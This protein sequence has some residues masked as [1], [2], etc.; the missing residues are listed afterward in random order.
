[1]HRGTLGQNPCAVHLGDS[2]PWA[3]RN[4]RTPLPKVTVSHNAR[5]ECSVPPIADSFASILH[6]WPHVPYLS[7]FGRTQNGVK[8]EFGGSVCRRYLLGHIS[9]QSFSCS[10][11][12]G[13]SYQSSSGKGRKVTLGGKTYQPVRY[14][15]RS[16][17]M[18]VES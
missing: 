3:A 16:L 9:T 14:A 7:A 12:R 4:G 11:E 18:E 17:H 2:G 5:T 8:K 13:I 15:T 10:H 1:M 6:T